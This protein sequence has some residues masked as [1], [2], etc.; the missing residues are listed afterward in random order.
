VLSYQNTTYMH[1]AGITILPPISLQRIVFPDPIQTSKGTYHHLKFQAEVCKGMH[2]V[3][4]KENKTLSAHCSYARTAYFIVVEET[5]GKQ[6]HQIIAR[7]VGKVGKPSG[8]FGLGMTS[9]L[10]Y[11]NMRA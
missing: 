9:T 6:E 7:V 5:L 3:Q 11:C 10:F 1:D 4:L 2:H 8:M